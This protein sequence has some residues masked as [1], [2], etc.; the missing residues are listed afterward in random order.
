MLNFPLLSKRHRLTDD[1]D[2]RR[3]RRLGKALYSPYFIFS[4]ASSKDP[5][6]LRFGFIVSNKF[7]KRAVVRNKYKRLLRS[8]VEENISKFKM[9]YDIVFV[10]K[11]E[12]KNKDHEEISN[13]FNKILSKVSFFG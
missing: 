11:T 10:L 8:I 1:Y 12:I 6:L 13:Y 2:F 5:T 9:G 3:V 7:D 4:Y